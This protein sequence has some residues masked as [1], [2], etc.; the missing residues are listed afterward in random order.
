[1]RPVKGSMSGSVLGLPH[2]GLREMDIREHAALPLAYI[3]GLR[4]SPRNTL[5]A[6]HITSIHR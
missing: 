6:A 1:M 2:G 4:A 5:F 3:E